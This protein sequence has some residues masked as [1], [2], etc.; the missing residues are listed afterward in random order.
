[1]GA[2]GHFSPKPTVLFGDWRAQPI[3]DMV[4]I[5]VIVS[6]GCIWMVLRLYL[7]SW[8]RAFL[9]LLKRRL[10]KELKG[11]LSSDGVT[12]KYTNSD[13]VQ[14][15]HG[16]RRLKETQEYTEAFGVAVAQLKRRY[17]AKWHLKPIGRRRYFTCKLTSEDTLQA[18]PWPD[19]DLDSLSRFLMRFERKLNG[20]GTLPGGGPMTPGGEAVH[21]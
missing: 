11:Q 20:G 8:V 19:A 1:M 13:G 6:C 10:T 9:K 7:M 12:V 3:K 2:F 16:G 17:T 5:M 14:R 15:C 18:D 4:A 21:P